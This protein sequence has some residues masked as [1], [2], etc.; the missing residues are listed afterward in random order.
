MAA[1]RHLARLRGG[2]LARSTLQ[3]EELEGLD[4]E[5]K[6]AD[7]YRVAVR[8][9]LGALQGMRT[10]AVGATQQAAAAALSWEWQGAGTYGWYVTSA[11]P[12]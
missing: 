4:E 2:A 7:Q 9:A 6:G 11:P 12:G 1:Q 5:A 8:G 3:G 10:Q